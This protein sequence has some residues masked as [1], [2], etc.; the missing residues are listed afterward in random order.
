MISVKSPS[1]LFTDR[2]KL[3]TCDR[4]VYGGRRLSN[5]NNLVYG[6]HGPVCAHDAGK[7]EER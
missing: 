2:Q 7:K 3:S 6:L 5:E 1:Q 4:L